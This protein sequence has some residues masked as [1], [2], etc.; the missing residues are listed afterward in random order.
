MAGTSLSTG[1]P[2]YTTRADADA[3]LVWRR[4]GARQWD[5]TGMRSTADGQTNIAKASLSG[6]FTRL[7]ASA[8]CAALRSNGH[9]DW[10]LPA[11]DE[12]GVLY[13][14]RSAIGG[15]DEES[16]TAYWS[17]SEVTNL[18]AWSQDFSDG[19]QNGAAKSMGLHVRCVRQP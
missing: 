5:K 17:S 4:D 3:L 9:A 7:S 19:F 18:F 10:Y 6:D 12:L 15:F 13:A 8:Y 1:R 14:G 16:G 2:L 11:K